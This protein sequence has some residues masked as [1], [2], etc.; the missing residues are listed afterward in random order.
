M[1]SANIWGIHVIFTWSYAEVLHVGVFCKI[2]I[3][4]DQLVTG[5]WKWIDQRE[6]L[7]FS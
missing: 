3:E 4:I 1:C 6:R 2:P 5:L 7:E